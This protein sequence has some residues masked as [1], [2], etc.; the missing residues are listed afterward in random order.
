MIIR[1]KE[2]YVVIL[3]IILIVFTFINIFGFKSLKN[4]LCRSNVKLKIGIIIITDHTSDFDNYEYATESM[5]CYAEMQNYDIEI[6]DDRN[7]DDRCP[8]HKDVNFY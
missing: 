8:N 2:Q 3:L 4:R 1:K 7:W 6:L 5:R